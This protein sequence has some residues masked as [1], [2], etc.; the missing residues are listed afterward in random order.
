MNDQKN[1][2]KPEK[3]VPKRDGSGGGT[4]ENQG[5]GGCPPS[6]N[7]NPDRVVIVNKRKDF[8]G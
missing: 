8:T 2:G 7:R 1:T 3:G 4:R 6:N 5:R